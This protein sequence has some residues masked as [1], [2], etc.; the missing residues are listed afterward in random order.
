M[1]DTAI[2]SE[3]FGKSRNGGLAGLYGVW[4]NSALPTNKAVGVAHGSKLDTEPA[5]SYNNVCWSSYGEQQIDVQ[6]KSGLVERHLQSVSKNPYKTTAKNW[7]RCK[8]Y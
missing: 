3:S 8:L 7:K 4:L 6:S 5:Y 1:L 2:V